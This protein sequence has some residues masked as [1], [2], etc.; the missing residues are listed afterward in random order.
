[1]SKHKSSIVV[2]DNL[3]LAEIKDKKKKATTE[4][5]ENICIRHRI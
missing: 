1:M 3:K 2:A 4:A 5:M